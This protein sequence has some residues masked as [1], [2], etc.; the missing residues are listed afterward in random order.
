LI[1]FAT[2]IGNTYQFGTAKGCA[3]L[4][5][6]LVLLLA[7]VGACAVVFATVVQAALMQI[8]TTNGMWISLF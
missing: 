6:Y 8:F 1:W 5:V 2:I 7:I 4:F 3:T